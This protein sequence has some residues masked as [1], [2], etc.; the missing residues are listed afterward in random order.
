MKGRQ[1]FVHF[2]FKLTKIEL[3][4]NLPND[5]DPLRGSLM[6]KQFKFLTGS[7]RLKSKN[8]SRQIFVDFYIKCS[9]IEIHKNLPKPQLQE[10]DVGW[11]LGKF[12]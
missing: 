2:Y 3:Y 11:F 12:L 8:H 5:I 1:T 4:K 9:K 7:W 6:F 10:V